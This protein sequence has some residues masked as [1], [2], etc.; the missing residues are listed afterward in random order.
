MTDD[1][2]CIR[3]LR[4]GD[5]GC[6]YGKVIGKDCR[7]HPFGSDYQFIINEPQS[8]SLGNQCQ[9]QGQYHVHQ[10]GGGKGLL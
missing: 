8:R 3:Y 9:E 5:Q 10:Q 1:G 4:N 6:Q 2:G 7:R